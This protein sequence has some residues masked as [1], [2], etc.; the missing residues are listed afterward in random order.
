MTKTTWIGTSGNYTDPANWS[1]G[2]PT[3][4]SFG[5]ITDRGPAIDG[6]VVNATIDLVA[7]GNG[8]VPQLHLD[9]GSGTIGAQAVVNMLTAAHAGSLP[10][11]QLIDD[12]KL[13]NSGLINI[14]SASNIAVGNIDIGVASTF[15]NL[16]T[17][18]DHAGSA[19]N[20]VGEPG[21]QVQN[22]GTIYVAGT[23][24]ILA[25]VTGN[26]TIDIAGTAT[27]HA[28]LWSD[29]TVGS[30]Q[31]INLGVDSTLSLSAPMGMLAAIHMVAASAQIDLTNASVTSMAYS[32]NELTLHNGALTVAVLHI[33]DG[34]NVTN[35]HVAEVGSTAVLTHT[36]P[37]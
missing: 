27:S 13:T 1:A 18:V 2:V 20:F 23:G 30:G 21:D 7:S 36:A 32:N 11:A 16:G 33:L 26:G 6:S 28:S 17:V 34:G 14:G 24:E 5:V 9:N 3:P 8:H 35:F 37:V 31:H 15:I 19:M 4:T 10:N 22:Q 29:M 25:Q 12:G